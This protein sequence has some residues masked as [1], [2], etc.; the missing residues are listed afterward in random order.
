M[1]YRFQTMFPEHAVQVLAV[2]DVAPN[3]LYRLGNRVRVPVGQVVIH[4][5][6]MPSF[7]EGLNSGRSYISR[8]TGDQYLHASIVPTSPGNLSPIWAGR[9]PITAVARCH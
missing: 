4:H 5:D 9:P 1:Q 7:E 3:Q 8:T 2:T 6:F